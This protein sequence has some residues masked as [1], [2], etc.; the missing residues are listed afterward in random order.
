MTSKSYS[1]HEIEPAQREFVTKSQILSSLC[2]DI[3]KVKNFNTISSEILSIYYQNTLTMVG[4]YLP[5][6][7]IQSTKRKCVTESQNVVSVCFAS[8]LS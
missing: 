2:A 6:T 3:Q 8:S 4:K 5:A 7:K 1:T